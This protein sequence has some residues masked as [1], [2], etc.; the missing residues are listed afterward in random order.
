VAASAIF[1]VSPSEWLRKGQYAWGLS[2]DNRQTTWR[3]GK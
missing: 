2:A 3:C 1:N